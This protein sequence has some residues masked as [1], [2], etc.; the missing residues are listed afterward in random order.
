MTDID[1]DG[2]GVGRVTVFAG[3]GG[4]EFL[5]DRSAIK[6]EVI[7]FYKGLMGIAAP[8]VNKLIMRKGPQLQQLQRISLIAPVTDKEIFASSN[9][10][11]D[12]KAPE[13]THPQ[14][15]L[16]ATASKLFSQASGLVANLCKSS[17]YFGGVTKEEQ[18]KILQILGF[19][20]GELPFKYLGVPL[21]TKKISLIQWQPLLDRITSRISSWTAK[22]LS[23]AGRAQLIKSAVFGI[24]AYWT[25]LFSIPA[26]VLHLIDAHCKSY[27]WAGSG[28][29]SFGSLG[30]CL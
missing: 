20:Y 21:A 25:Q 30:V 29:E 9:A 17:V 12:D 23:Y 6:D 22:N 15:L 14:H 2:N 8:A 3:Q 27:L 19:S 18:D 13:E 16:S 5:R 10:I 4:L 7:S 24:Q 11:E 28:E 26:K 1:R